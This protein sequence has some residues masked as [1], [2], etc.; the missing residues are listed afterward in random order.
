MYHVVLC[1]C[2]ESV[3]RVNRYLCGSTERPEPR[4]TTALGSE[5]SSHKQTAAK[6]S[7]AHKLNRT[8]IA[9]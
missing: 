6:G 2:E 8:S 4:L 7:K 5:V 3:F 1:V 9:H